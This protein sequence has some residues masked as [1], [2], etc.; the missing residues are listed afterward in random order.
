MSEQDK[1]MEILYTLVSTR[2]K[3]RAM[4]LSHHNINN[5]IL[6]LWWDTLKMEPQVS[7]EYIEKIAL[8]W[9]KRKFE[10]TVFGNKEKN[11]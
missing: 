2:N 7:H 9:K 3:M 11:K 1:Y 4:G 10:E 8:N 6:D 5:E